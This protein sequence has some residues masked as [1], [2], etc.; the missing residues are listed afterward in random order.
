MELHKIPEEKFK[1]L[2]YHVFQILNTEKKSEYKKCQ[3]NIEELK[4]NVDILKEFGVFK[5]KIVQRKTVVRKK[6][7]AISKKG[8]RFLRNYSLINE[9]RDNSNKSLD[10]LI[11]KNH[12]IKNNEK[13][14]T[15]DNKGE[16]KNN[17]KKIKQ[18]KI[19]HSDEENPNEESSKNQNEIFI[20]NFRINTSNGEEISNKLVNKYSQYIKNTEKYKLNNKIYS[21]KHYLP[22]IKTKSSLSNKV[23]NSNNIRS[24]TLNNL[25]EKYSYINNLIKED[26]KTLNEK[27]LDDF[28]SYIQTKNSRIGS[29]RPKIL[30]VNENSVLQMSKKNKRIVTSLKHV[31]NNLE[32]ANLEFETKF[33]YFNWKY[34][35]ADM[36]KYF[37]DLQSY[38]KTEEDL[39]NKRKSFY[40]RLDDVID[41]IKQKE[42]MKKFNKIAKQFGIKIKED[43]DKNNKAIE[44][45][46][47]ILFKNKEVK[48]SLKKLYQRQKNEK[49][50]NGK[51]KQILERC[52]ERFININMKLDGY[53]K[54]EMKLKEA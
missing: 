44:E 20:T 12:Y 10:K 46:D 28:F 4:Y 9:S 50:K 7:R 14:K 54:K 53:K 33:K 5:S 27:K 13:Q 15:L 31:K 34:G 40:D 11:K 48:N 6:P 38:K 32:E 1:H 41:D 43:D 47:K 49:E 2:S 18:D 37:I 45:S 3:K 39:I 52:K 21:L 24:S 23:L 8:T 35:I 19:I 25:N 22:P 16:N 29:R 36:N 30:K 26:N 42:Q 17:Q 51:I